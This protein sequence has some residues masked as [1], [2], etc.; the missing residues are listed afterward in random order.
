VRGELAQHHG[1]G[2]E[3]RREGIPGDLL[4]TVR[5]KRGEKR[6]LSMEGGRS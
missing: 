5:E 2:K 3:V 1:A 4:P 6:S